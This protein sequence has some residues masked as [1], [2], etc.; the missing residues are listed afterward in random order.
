MKLHRRST[1]E[2]PFYA[3]VLSV[4]GEAPNHKLAVRCMEATVGFIPSRME[5]EDMEAGMW[6]VPLPEHL[7]KAIEN[8]GGFAISVAVDG[9][10]Y[11]I[12]A[13]AP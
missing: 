4:D 10:E 6:S 7:G 5:S 9:R 2:Q 3:V 12:C 8:G 1:D 13:E 11:S